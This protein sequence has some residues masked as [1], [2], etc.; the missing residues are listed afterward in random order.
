MAHGSWRHGGVTVGG[1]ILVRFCVRCYVFYAIEVAGV[2]VFRI[3]DDYSPRP[4]GSGVW[5]GYISLSSWYGSTKVSAAVARIPQLTASSCEKKRQSRARPARGEMRSG[6]PPP[7][8]SQTCGAA[9]SDE[10]GRSPRRGRP[11]L[12]PISEASSRS[13]RQSALTLGESPPSLSLPFA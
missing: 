8:S 13:P 4:L 7:A 5:D 1:A 11:D 3:P 6:R 9:R 12:A 10:L 2:R